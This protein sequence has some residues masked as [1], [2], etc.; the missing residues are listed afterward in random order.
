MISFII[1]GKNE[2]WRLKLCLESVFNVVDKDGIKDYEVI[3]V[4]SKSTDDSITIAQCYEKIKIYQITGECNAA[5]ARNIGAK[6]ASGDILF[7]I[8]G[9]MEIQPGF[10][11][12]IFSER[13]GLTYPFITGLFQNIMYDC[14]WRFLY[15]DK[16]NESDLDVFS[17]TVG[18]LFLVERKYW[19]SLYG[20]DTR[21]RRSQDLDFGL[22]MAK[23]YR[24]L[25][26]RKSI[27]LA[28]HHTT[29]YESRKDST[30]YVSY[31]AALFR[32]HWNN[33]FYFKNFIGNRYTTLVLLFAVTLLY[34]T[35]CYSI[36][37]YLFAI[38]YKSVSKKQKTKVSLYKQALY[39]IKLDVRFIIA[40]ICFYPMSIKP[41]YNKLDTKYHD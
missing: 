3:Y 38:V 19:D 7:F 18:G 32:K 11:S 23:K 26:C 20:M 29:A 35:S 13:K 22:R 17:S 9:D 21:L 27:F 30:S 4:D 6:E 33:K 40:M 5:V 25:L 12:K 1:I 2:G 28:K 31:S 8:D 10:L 41:E 36:F 34:Y 14:D 39:L 37:L 16:I 15:A 24:L